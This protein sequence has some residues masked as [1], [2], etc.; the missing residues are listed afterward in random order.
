METQPSLYHGRP[1][2]VI[3]GDEIAAKIKAAIRD[4]RVRCLPEDIGSVNQFLVSVDVLNNNGLRQKLRGL[5][6]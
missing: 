2:R 6:E 5:Y 4:E 1:F 3:H